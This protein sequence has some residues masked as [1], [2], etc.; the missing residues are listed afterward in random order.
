[1]VAGEPT[2][3]YITLIE[4]TVDEGSTQEGCSLEIQKARRHTA[5]D[6]SR[7][8]SCA[9]RCSVSFGLGTENAVHIAALGFAGPA[10]PPDLLTNSLIHPPP[11]E[12]GSHFWPAICRCRF[13]PRPAS[14]MVS[15]E[16]HHL[17]TLA[18][19]TCQDAMHD[20]SPLAAEPAVRGQLLELSTSIG[21]L[22]ELNCW[23]Q[24]ILAGADTLSSM[25]LCLSDAGTSLNSLV[26]AFRETCARF[27][28]CFNRGT[29]PFCRRLSRTARHLCSLLASPSSFLGRSCL[30]SWLSVSL[31]FSPEKSARWRQ[32]R[33][34][35]TLTDGDA[36]CQA[37]LVWRRCRGARHKLRCKT[38]PP[39]IL[40]ALA[41]QL[42]A[43]LGFPA[44]PTVRFPHFE[45]NTRG[46]RHRMH[47]SGQRQ[48]NLCCCLD[49]RHACQC[50]GA[51]PLWPRLGWGLQFSP[52][53]HGSV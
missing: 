53:P 39:V 8:W 28:G 20:S 6:A 2:S 16:A 24:G 41:L 23:K 18:R 13:A 1:M 14:C 9:S 33:T 49:Q 51:N 31:L 22:A 34:S 12:V 17:F 10:W 7:T 4:L 40:D 3:T 30:G 46:K 42:L 21:Q 48:D 27:G 43:A 26:S 11:S 36:K 37:S 50:S 52:A 45:E 15:G 25:A 29:A 35:L 5:D 44:S 38:P 47:P 19:A 32:C